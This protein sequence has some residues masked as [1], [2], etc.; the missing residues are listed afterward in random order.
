MSVTKKDEEDWEQGKEEWLKACGM[1]PK[2]LGKS[3]TKSGAEMQ[4]EA[5]KG[6]TIMEVI[7]VFKKRL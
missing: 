1:N 3:N 5:C 6:K 2:L 4:R 7:D